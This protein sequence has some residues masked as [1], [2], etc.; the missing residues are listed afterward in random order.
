MGYF[1]IGISLVHAA[2]F[3]SVQSGNWNATSTWG[4]STVPGVGDTVS[5]ADGTTVTVTASTTVG[6]S[7]NAYYSYIS[8]FIVGG[9]IPSG[10]GTCSV[11]LNGS[12][13]PNDGNSAQAVNCSFSG[14]VIQVTDAM[15]LSWY[16]SSTVLGTS[17]ISCSPSCAGTTVAPVWQQGSGT[18]AIE[19]NNSGNLVIAGQ[20]TVR[21][22]I[23]Y[24]AAYANTSDAVDMAGGAS[25]I[26]D[27]SHAASLADGTKPYYTFGQRGGDS[28]GRTFGMSTGSPCTAIARCTVSSSA[29]GSPAAFSIHGFTFGG[30][31]A[32]KYA[33]LSNLGN[34]VLPWDVSWES[35]YDIEHSFLTNDGP[36]ELF[37][38]PGWASFIDDYN[39]YSGTMGVRY[40]GTVTGRGL[41]RFKLVK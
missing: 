37:N 18:A 25:L 40:F 26:F 17:S 39:T 13:T 16:A 12:S 38:V 30:P 11:T 28:G 36:A 1:L 29:S 27:S 7:A 32:L 23:S 34:T 35:T 3:T 14:G 33:T 22:D 20:L 19:L 5:I 4:S 10:S 41:G 24:R 31:I 2:A 6:T 21:G 15:P 8:S 9:T